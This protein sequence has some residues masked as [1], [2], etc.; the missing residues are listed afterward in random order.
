MYTGENPGFLD[1]HPCVDK[2]GQLQEDDVEMGP[3]VVQQNRRQDVNQ[4]QEYDIITQDQSI[5]EDQ[6]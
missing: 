6:E 2:R 3:V 4:S 1:E 5:E